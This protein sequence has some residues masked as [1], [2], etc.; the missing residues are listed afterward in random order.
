M[1]QINKI[2]LAT[3]SP[4]VLGLAACTGND[5]VNP[6]PDPKPTGGYYTEGREIDYI[7]GEKPTGQKFYNE[8][9]TN[10]NFP[11]DA[12]GRTYTS[13][14]A[15]PHIVK[16]D[17][18]Y[19]YMFSTN[20]VGLKSTDGCNWEVFS[21]NIIDRP[22]W[23]DAFVKE[24]YPDKGSPQVW[25][26]D[27]IKIKDKWIYYYSLSAWGAPV[28][29]GYATSDNPD[30]PYVDQGKLFFGKEL[31]IKNCIDP[32]I[33]REG[34]DVYMVVG[35]FQGCYIVEL[36]EDG[37]SLY[38]DDTIEDK[39]AYWKEHKTLVAGYD[40]NWDGATYEGTYLTKKGEYYYLFGS[41]GTCCAGKDSTYS[42][43]VG[44]SKDILGP[45]VGKDNKPMTMSGYSSTFGEL[46][47]W[48]G[49]PSAEK[50]VYGPGH[51]SILVDDAGNWWMYYHGYLEKDTYKTRHF[52]M[53]RIYWDDDGY[54]YVG[55]EENGN[56][57]RPSYDVELEGPSIL[58]VE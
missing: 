25:A 23:G 56:F 10:G 8:V 50:S 48:A 14:V 4:M 30:G 49:S 15:D 2:L 31:G 52:L 26:P 13:E 44:R 36:S 33:F 1:K 21:T 35:S 47:L 57:K 12:S 41:V 51:N 34:N 58:D 27:V 19:F 20:R 5:P 43:F 24:N 11:M 39:F 54:P 3:I 9:Y 7:E 6:G 28:G 55:S 38:E 40:G 45:Y 46:V 17:D 22:T 18:G 37:F 42:V 53:D 16:G 29:I 32:C